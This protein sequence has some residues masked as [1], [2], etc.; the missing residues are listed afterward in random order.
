MQHSAT[1][2]PE[3]N[4]LRLYPACRLSSEEYAR[5]KSAGFKWAPRQELF[6]APMWTPEREDLLLEMCGEIGD[7]DTTL[8]DRAEAKADRLEDLSD[9][10]A[11][12]ARQAKAAVDA[13]A[14]GI[15]FG[16]PILVGH[17]SEKRARK[18]AGR[19]ESGMR[20][21]VKMWDTAQ[22][23]KDR[24][25]GALHHAKYKE[26]PDV[27]A[28]RIKKIEADLRRCRSRYTPRPPDQTPTMMTAICEDEPTPH[29]FC[30]NG[31]RGGS[32]VKVSSLEGIK[33]RMARWDAHY[34]NRLTY[35][36]AMLDEQGGTVADQV[37]PEKGGACRCW[38]SPR[39]GWSIIQR[40]NK[41][42][43]SLLD[44]WGNGGDDFK[45][46]IEFHELKA[47]MTKAQVDEARAAGRVVNET[48]RGFFLLAEGEAP[49]PKPKPEPDPEKAEFEALR[50][51]ARVGV[52]T[53]SAP[54]LFPTPEAIATRLGALARINHG[55]RILE[56]SAGTGA[57]IAAIYARDN[58]ADV[59]AVEINAALVEGLQQ[60]WSRG[61]YNFRCLQADFLECNGDLG[62]FDRIVM[63]PPFQN[64]ADITHI[65]HARHMLKPGGRLVAI[66]ANGPR[67]RE[68]LRPEAVA[69]YDLPE[70]SFKSEGTN[71]NAAIAVFEA[72]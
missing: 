72:D 14:D 4:K 29:V 17:H 43:V 52:K 48:H 57:L 64:G 16:Q 39:G 37:K 30:G 60:R 25:A 8:V 45:R 5:V 41:V 47:V 63:N 51:T 68:K 3:D 44:N 69:W 66:C 65:E 33:A 49:K 54:Q 40:V 6:V 28:R 26:R 12:D 70:G 18:D 2:S 58:C 9:K 61:N 32:W 71:V 59:Q 7:E 56:P 53:V 34:Q 27:R 38:C 15:P 35:E 46:R 1:Y 13:I 10:R 23:W 11:T 62:T 36:R 31:S 55:Q 22:Y 50:R 24:A 42:S 67:Q 20:K 21:A 19:I